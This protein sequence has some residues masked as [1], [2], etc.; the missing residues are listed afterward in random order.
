MV[1]AR[2]PP[3]ADPANIQFFLPTATVRIC[4][5]NAVVVDRE[6]AVVEVAR[7]RTVQILADCRILASDPRH[8]DARLVID[9]RHFDGEATDRVLPPP[10]LGKMGLRLQQIAALE[11]QRRPINLYAALAEVARLAPHASPP[12]IS[13]TL[14]TSCTGAFDHA[15]E[16]RRLG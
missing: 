1:A 3:S 15:G 13:T 7:Q 11:P 16:G 2:R 5:S 14:A 10:P 8:T 12:S 4:R 6:L 9:Q